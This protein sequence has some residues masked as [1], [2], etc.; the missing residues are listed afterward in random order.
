C[1]HVGE[2]V[3]ARDGLALR[4]VAGVAAQVEGQADAA[5]RREFVRARHVLLLAAVPAMHQQHAGHDR[6][7]GDEGA[8]EALAFDLD[9]DEAVPGRH[10]GPTTV[11]FV[12]GP[13]CAASPLKYTVALG[14]G[15][16]PSP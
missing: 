14:G 16:T 10:H 6:R 4:G 12:I 3:L 1:Q 2:A 5:Q 8:G 13:T 7:R 11:Y 9:L 15:T